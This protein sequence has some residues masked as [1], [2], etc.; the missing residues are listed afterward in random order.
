M[1]PHNICEYIYIYIYIYI[2]ENAYSIYKTVGIIHYSKI[3]KLYIK[4]SIT[5]RVN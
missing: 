2:D 4:V 3:Y 1:I 5:N